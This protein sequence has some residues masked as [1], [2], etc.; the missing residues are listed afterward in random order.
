MPR[1]ANGFYGLLSREQFVEAIFHFRAPIGV[2]P[3]QRLSHLSPGTAS[4]SPYEDN[5][6]GKK[7][8]GSSLLVREKIRRDIHAPEAC[9]Q[10]KDRPSFPGCERLR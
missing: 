8:G 5:T 1:E 6:F 2:K 9:T 10:T 7:I 3:S 4:S